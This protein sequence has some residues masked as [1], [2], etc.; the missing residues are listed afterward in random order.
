MG[1]RGIAML[2]SCAFIF[3]SPATSVASVTSSPQPSSPAT[4]L[5]HSLTPAQRDSIAAARAAFAVA[6]KNALDGFDRAV[7]DAQAVRDQAISA[8]GTDQRS[9]RLAKKI[10]RDSYRTILN[11]YKSD[12]KDAKSKFAKAIVAIKGASKIS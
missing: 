4:P 11:A 9:V 8:A 5:A 10:Y 6:K 1:K 12:L 3:V 7:A 2:I